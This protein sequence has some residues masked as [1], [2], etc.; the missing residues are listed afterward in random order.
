MSLV[1]RFKRNALKLAS[2]SGSFLAIASSVRMRA[3]KEGNIVKDGLARLTD[4]I[5]SG[6]SSAFA[7][8]TCEYPLPLPPSSMTLNQ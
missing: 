6:F 5:L 3:F 2:A 7:A 8:C 1:P 4:A